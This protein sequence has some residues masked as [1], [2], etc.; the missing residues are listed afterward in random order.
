MDQ[1]YLEKVDGESPT[2]KQFFLVENT[3]G[4]Q[5]SKKRHKLKCKSRLTFTAS[6]FKHAKSQ[7]LYCWRQTGAKNTELKKN[8]CGSSILGCVRKINN[9]I[10]N[11]KLCQGKGKFPNIIKS[12]YDPHKR[13]RSSC[14]IFRF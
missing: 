11:A 2:K 14:L 12:T 1:S 6:S 9:S 5:T 13:K 4:F 10:F 8:A 3:F 7:E